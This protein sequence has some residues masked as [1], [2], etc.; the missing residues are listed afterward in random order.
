MM[1]FWVV[2][3]FGAQLSAKSYTS[4]LLLLI[5]EFVSSS[6]RRN[7]SST[8]VVRVE[9]NWPRR[10]GR[11]LICGSKTRVPTNAKFASRVFNLSHPLLNLNFSACKKY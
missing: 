7:H 11:A 5:T 2:S 3:E 4:S 9:E 1:G 6:T 10:T 8:W